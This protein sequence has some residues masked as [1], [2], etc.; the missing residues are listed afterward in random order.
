MNFPER[1]SE[2][3]GTELA[4]EILK[5]K[6]RDREEFFLDQAV[7]GNFPDFIRATSTITLPER[8]EL[9]V[10]CDHLCFGTDED[11][12]YGQVNIETAQ[13]IADVLCARLPTQEIVDEI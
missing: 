9:E 5:L 12:I 11:F 4:A 2:M 13:K 1:S 6:G 8:G 7:K 10:T 3:T